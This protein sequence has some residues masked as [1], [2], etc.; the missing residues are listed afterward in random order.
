MVCSVIA[1]SGLL[2][3]EVL[4]HMDLSAIYFIM[5]ATQLQSL[6]SHCN[7]FTGTTD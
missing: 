5:A 6:Q 2:F 7:D 1:L 4:Q 3:F